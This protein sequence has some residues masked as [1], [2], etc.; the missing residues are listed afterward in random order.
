VPIVGI[1]FACSEPVDVR[2]DPDFVRPRPEDGTVAFSRISA[3]SGQNYE[4]RGAMLFA[5]GVTASELI[6]SGFQVL[7]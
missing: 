3:V 7:Y 1:L 6:E 5:A 2:N 4:K